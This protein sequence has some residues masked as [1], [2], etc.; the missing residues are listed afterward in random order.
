MEAG[1]ARIGAAKNQP[2]WGAPFGIIPQCGF[3]AAASGLYAGR[4]I[5][6]GTLM[7]VYLSTSDE[8]LPSDLI[9]CGDYVDLHCAKAGIAMISG[10]VIDLVIRDCR[11][12]ADEKHHH[13]DHE[14]EQGCEERLALAALRHTMEVFIYIAGISFLLNLGIAA[15]GEATLARFF[16]SIPVLGEF[17]AALVGLI[18]NCASSVV[19]TEL[20]LSGVIGAGAMM[21]GLLVN[22]GVGI[23]VLLRIDHDRKETANH[24]ALYAWVFWGLSSMHLEWYSK[25]VS[26]RG[27]DVWQ[28]K[29][30]MRLQA[31]EKYWRS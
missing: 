17:L 24:M 20:Y 16:T 22:A 8:M 2:I 1:R 13:H 29:I 10:I 23:L 26:E 30:I 18:P 7:A 25:V 6:I 27:R 15:I 9:L 4:I 11:K 12:T 3:S 28:E 14:G 21:S 31:A 19:I 5:T